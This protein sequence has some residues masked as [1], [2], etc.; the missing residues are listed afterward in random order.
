MWNPYNLERL[1]ALGKREQFLCMQKKRDFLISLGEEREGHLLS[2]QW[3]W[4]TYSTASET[5]LSSIWKMEM[6]ASWSKQLKYF[7]FLDWIGFERWEKRRERRTNEMKRGWGQ[8]RWSGMKLTL[9]AGLA[10]GHFKDS[11]TYDLICNCLCCLFVNVFSL[12]SKQA[13]DL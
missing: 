7:F 10:W 12:D 6:L 11:D 13:P 4:A 3:Y 9:T 8:V 1:I 5:F 2:V